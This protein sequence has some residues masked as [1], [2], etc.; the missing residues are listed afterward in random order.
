M[1]QVGLTLHVICIF[2]GILKVCIH[3]TGELLIE[4]SRFAMQLLWSA[5]VIHRSRGVL[6]EVICRCLCFCSQCTDNEEESKYLPFFF[7]SETLSSFQQWGLASYLRRG[8]LSHS[9]VCVGC[10]SHTVVFSC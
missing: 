6:P 10:C 4:A 9:L 2:L 7:N 1:D 5:S 3:P 8:L